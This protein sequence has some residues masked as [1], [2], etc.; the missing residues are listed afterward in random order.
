M[1]ENSSNNNNY[2]NIINQME[3]ILHKL[4]QYKIPQN[5]WLLFHNHQYVTDQ[6]NTINI[7]EIG[8]LFMV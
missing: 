2:D 8:K 1:Q 5:L 6:R 3:Q 7:S 4:L